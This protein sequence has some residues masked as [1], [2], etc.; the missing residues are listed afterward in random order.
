MCTSDKACDSFDSVVIAAP[1][2]LAGLELEAGLQP[3]APARQYQVTVATFVAASGL[4]ATYFGAKDIV[5]EDTVMTTDN[6]SIPFNSVS[7]H[8]SL[9]SRKVYK[10]FSK[11]VP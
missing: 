3:A 11:N 5:E 1:L 9:G 6:A 10:L 7:V 2:E 4:N 8:A